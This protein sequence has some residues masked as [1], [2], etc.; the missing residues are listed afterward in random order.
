M[1]RPIGAMWIV[2]SLACAGTANAQNAVKVPTPQRAASQPATSS[3]AVQAAEE[4]R[5]PG[6]MRPEKR[7]V[8]QVVVPLKRPAPSDDATASAASPAPSGV[9]DEVARCLASNDRRERAACH[10]LTKGRKPIVG[11]AARAG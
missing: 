9:D 3:P 10:A 1:N 7:P 11:P 4:A 6:E 2:A 5:V 8:P